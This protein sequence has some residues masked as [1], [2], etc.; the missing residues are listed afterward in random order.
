MSA[1]GGGEAGRLVRKNRQESASKLTASQK[2]W[3]GETRN[4]ENKRFKP[5]TPDYLPLMGSGV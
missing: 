3:H 1:R 2:N 5:A 4:Q